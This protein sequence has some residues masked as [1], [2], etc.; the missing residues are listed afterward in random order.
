MPGLTVFD[1]ESESQT[2]VNHGS[3]IVDRR[4]RYQRYTNRAPRSHCL[5][6]RKWTM[7]RYTVWVTRN[8]QW[9][10][11]F[12][13]RTLYNTTV[14]EFVSLSQSTCLNVVI[15]KQTSST[16]R[17]LHQSSQSKTHRSSALRSRTFTP[18]N[19]VAAKLGA[20]GCWGMW[21]DPRGLEGEDRGLSDDW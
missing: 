5:Q 8:K 13:M 19:W 16:S 11:H 15:K 4:S 18:Q 20:R 14:P 10:V 1:S 12:T 21:N 17:I 2:N 9:A 7:S 6:H 3:A